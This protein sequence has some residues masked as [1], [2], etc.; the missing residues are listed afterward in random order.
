MTITVGLKQFTTFD[1][2]AGAVAV[3]FTGTTTAGSTISVIMQWSNARG[4]GRAI[5]ADP[6]LTGG[7]LTWNKRKS[8]PQTTSANSVGCVAWDAINVGAVTNLALSFAMGAPETT[9]NYGNVSVLEIKGADTTAPFEAANGNSAASGTNPT[10][11]T[12][13][14][15]NTTTDGIAHVM[16]GID[17][18]ANPSITTNPPTGYTSIGLQADQT[19]HQGSE[20]AYKILTS[21]A[22]QSASWAT[23]STGSSGGW[24]AVIVVYKGASSGQSVTGT[25]AVTSSTA[26]T[27]GTGARGSP[28][29]GAVSSSKAT[30]S[31]TG[32][33][34]GGAQSVTGT[35]A[36]QS[37]KATA[38]GSGTRGIQDQPGAVSVSTS[39]PTVS[40]SGTVNSPGSHSGTGAVQSSKA[41]AAGTGVR[42]ITGSGALTSAPATVRGFQVMPKGRI[43][44]EFGFGLQL[45]F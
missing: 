2:N 41:T 6:V 12:N 36:V 22:S 28:G 24:D 33:V 27:S 13:S 11:S 35:G 44:Q 17:S 26:T 34:N 15:S 3:T 16:A 5:N 42:G 39:I 31:G 18:G 30:T 43:Y 10:M 38:S 32:S 9:A 20:S 21:A 29:T 4:D 37:S 25:G 45:R 8:Q 19:A 1:N 23:D 7:G 14:A 40:G